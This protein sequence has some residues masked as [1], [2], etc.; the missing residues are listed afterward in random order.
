M[1]R[2]IL[3]VAAMAWGASL[4]GAPIT[5]VVTGD[6]QARAMADEL[7]QRTFNAAGMPAVVYGVTSGGATSATYAGTK[8]DE[9]SDPQAFHNFADDALAMHPDIVTF[10]LGVNDAIQ[11]RVEEYFQ[12]IAPEFVKLASAGVKV[13][14][15]TAMPVLPNPDN[16]AFEQANVYLD[17]FLNPWLRAHASAYGFHVLDLSQLIQQQ[18]DWQSWYSDDGASPGYVHLWG[19]FAQGTSPGYQWM[20]RQLLLDCAAMYGGD[21]N[22]DGVA[23]GLDYI[24]WSEHYLQPG[25]FA[26]GDFNLDGVVDGLDYIV[27]ADHYEARIAGE[28]T[29]AATGQLAGVVPVPE[30]SGM[31]LAYGAAVMAIVA[32]G[33]RRLCRRAA[34]A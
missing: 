24:A 9:H 14:V 27:W 19:A 34:V 17:E 32:G 29:S 18:P 4:Q 26:D 30:P 25:G 16:A 11:G 6:S 3:L 31:A 13:I 8:L 28:A 12:A 33:R 15:T 7:L 5:I 2:G 20:A 22:L 1:R 10:T 23:N 21:A